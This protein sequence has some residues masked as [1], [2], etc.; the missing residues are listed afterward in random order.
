MAARSSKPKKMKINYESFNIPDKIIPSENIK[1]EDINE[2]S[3]ENMSE[4]LARSILETVKSFLKT[5]KNMNKISKKTYDQNIKDLKEVEKCIDR[6][7][8]KI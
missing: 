1:K 3:L 2:E 5:M 8:K 7:F 4:S 6:R